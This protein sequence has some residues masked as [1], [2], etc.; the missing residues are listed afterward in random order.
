MAEQQPPEPIDTDRP[1]HRSDLGD[2]PFAAFAEWFA[3]AE[4][5]GEPQPNALA[6]ATSTNDMPDVRIVLLHRAD[7]AGFVFFTNY[8]SQKGRELAVNPEAAIAIHWALLHRQVRAVGTVSRTS[9]EESE[10]YWLGRPWGSRIASAASRQSAVTPSRAD[11]QAR[12]H[13]LEVEYPEPAAPDQALPP[14]P[15]SWGGFRLRPRWI[16]FWQGRRNRLHDRIRFVSDGDGW[17]T[18]RLDP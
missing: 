1:L 9:R 2:E 13:A 15:A 16:E 5:A 14:L 6:L 11:L 3:L 17:R 12:V 4:R 8:E 7:E 18:E 10:A